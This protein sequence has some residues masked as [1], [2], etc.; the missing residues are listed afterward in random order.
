MTYHDNMNE[1][2]ENV[3]H[4]DTLLSEAAALATDLTAHKHLCEQWLAHN[5]KWKQGLKDKLSI[6]ASMTMPVVTALKQCIHEKFSEQSVANL[7]ASSKKESY[8]KMHALEVWLEQIISE[9]R[10]NN[11]EG[12]NL[13]VKTQDL[14][15][16]ESM[17]YL[18]LSN[19]QGYWYHGTKPLGTKNPYLV[20]I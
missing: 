4:I 8:G 1:L 6:A 14:Q 3:P 19:Y 18:K 13:Y 17:F 10:Q 5:P 12:S 20:K 2:I 16:T 11:E 7:N 9:L 15:R